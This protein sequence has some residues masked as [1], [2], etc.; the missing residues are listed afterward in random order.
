MKNKNNSVQY[1]FIRHGKLDLPYKNHSEMPISILIEIASGKM[2][3]SVD[4]DFINEKLPVLKTVLKNVDSI[5]VSSLKRGIE[6]GHI[7][8]EFIEQ[9][10]GNN[11]D[12]F[13]EDN[14][15]EVSFDL[16]KVIDG[17]EYIPNLSQLNN[18]VFEAMSGLRNGAETSVSAFNRIKKVIK[19]Y[20]STDKV[21]LII[22]H[23]F[24]LETLEMYLN[25]K[26]VENFSGSYEELL[27]SPKINYL[28]GFTTD[29]DLNI[30]DFISV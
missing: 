1:I 2:N 25:N 14:L 5:V 3:P 15:K 19:K 27:K 23:S 9:K 28:S 24:L 7:I 26:N 11:I 18:L 17:L 30:I 29:K 16:E 21:I 12:F 6:T 8:S 4:V 13:I 22:T 10:I 20:N